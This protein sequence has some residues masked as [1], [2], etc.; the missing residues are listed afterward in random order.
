MYLDNSS[1]QG[2]FLLHE[3]GRVLRRG[4]KAGF[5]GAGPAWGLRQPL[6]VREPAHG[7]RGA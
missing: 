3:Q 6:F 1:Y 4:Y 2:L 7:D 5:T